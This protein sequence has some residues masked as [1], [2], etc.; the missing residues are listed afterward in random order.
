MITQVQYRHIHVFVIRRI[1]LVNLEQMT[2]LEPLVLIY[3]H[4]LR[5]KSE[6]VKQHTFY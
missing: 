6:F 3:R 4:I 1:S 2:I 5:Y